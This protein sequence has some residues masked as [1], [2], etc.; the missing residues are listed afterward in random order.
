MFITFMLG[1]LLGQV[2]PSAPVAPVRLASS[3]QQSARF[4]TPEEIVAHWRQG[5]VASERF[6]IPVDWDTDL[7]E[8]APPELAAKRC[9]LTPMH[10]LEARLH[11]ELA[12]RVTVGAEPSTPILALLL[13]Q[14]AL[15][16][17]RGGKMWGYN[18][19]GLKSS[20]GGASLLTRESFGV[21]ARRVVQRF[22]TYRSAVEGA[23]DYIQT[24]S[25]DF[26]RSFAALHSGSA[27]RFARA[28]SDE[29]YFT[30]SPEE[31]RRAVA[32]LAFEFERKMQAEAAPLG[33]NVMR[34][35]PV[36][37]R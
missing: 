7:A 17:G 12:Y 9:V 18:F 30:G 35:T 34:T 24:L 28:L 16:T 26:P 36:V 37:T 3:A 25:D 22:R 21:R 19:G 10:H 20:L 27:D 1:L 32:L 6:A 4:A 15:E 33:G 5:F 31:Y 2:S 13:A 14:W 8:E 29:G 11:L 23:R